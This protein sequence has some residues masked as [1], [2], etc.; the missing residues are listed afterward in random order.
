VGAELII[1]R[2]VARLVTERCPSH[3]TG[4]A[5][6]QPLVGCGEPSLVRARLVCLP[7]TCPPICSLQPLLPDDG[8]SWLRAGCLTEFD[9]EASRHRSAARFQHPALRPRPALNAFRAAFAW[10]HIKAAMVWSRFEGNDS[11]NA[12]RGAQ[13][14]ALYLPRK[15]PC[16]ARRAHYWAD[17]TA[18]AVFN[19]EASPWA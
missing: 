3:V 17:L 10:R 2:T 11:C 8:L 7:F 16:R 12:S 1:A 4:Y 6:L 18:P 9:G 15:L 5:T 14:R 19:R 13:G